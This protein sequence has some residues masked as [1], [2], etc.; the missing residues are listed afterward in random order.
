MHTKLSKFWLV[1][2]LGQENIPLKI[3]PMIS[4]FWLKSCNTKN[5]HFPGSFFCHPTCI[6]SCI[7][8]QN[9]M[10]LKTISE[11][12]LMISDFACATHFLTGIK[13]IV[14][15]LRERFF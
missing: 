3:S 4:T 15:L 9:N 2:F 6:K 1:A 14:I 7:H 13:V 8:A 11:T 10:F 12:C 5:V